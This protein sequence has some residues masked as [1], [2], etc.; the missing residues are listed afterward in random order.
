MELELYLDSRLEAYGSR[1]GTIYKLMNKQKK[2]I[3]RKRKRHRGN[4]K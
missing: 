4:E 1:I 2:L 3:Y